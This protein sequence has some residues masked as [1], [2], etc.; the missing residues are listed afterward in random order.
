MAAPFR[1]HKSELSLPHKRFGHIAVTW[2]KA[3]IIWGGKTSDQTIK[4][5]D[6]YMH[7]SGKWM[8]KETSGDAPTITSCAAAHVVD[9]TMFVLVPHG[10]SPDEYLYSLDLNT[11]TWTKL[12]PGGTPPTSSR[13]RTS[14]WVHNGRIYVLGGEVVEELIP[15]HVIRRRPVP[16][17]EQLLCYNPEENSWKVFNSPLR[18][19][20][21]VS[22]L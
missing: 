18:S 11:W 1:I 12:A 5:S 22:M 7:L 19:S 13:I 17:S 4:D 21:C 14:S 9:D 15:A 6:V 3:T 8:R 10:A 20:I 16:P 2:N